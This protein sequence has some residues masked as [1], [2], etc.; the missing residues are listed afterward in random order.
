MNARTNSRG[1]VGHTTYIVLIALQCLGLPLAFLV[2]PLHKV[3]G[4]DGRRGRV[5]A[6]DTTLRDEFRKGWALMRRRQMFLLV[7]I[8]VGFQWNTTYLGIYMTK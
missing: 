2:S 4:R 5:V 8:L 6:K 1:K 7:P 3:I